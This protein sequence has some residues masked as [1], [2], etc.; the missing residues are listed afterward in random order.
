MSTPKYLINKTATTLV[1]KNDMINVAP[2]KFALLTADDLNSASV[3]S[4]LSS[5]LV[6]ISDTAPEG[7]VEAPAEPEID[8]HVPFKGMSLEE[9]KASEAEESKKEEMIV[10]PLGGSVEAPAV[11][12]E[13][14]AEAPAKAGRKPK[15][16]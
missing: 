15:A 2:F 5:N 1:L 12:T 10:T 14:V 8:V 4:L 6:E 9:L 13:A 3:L 7:V 11:E 16:A